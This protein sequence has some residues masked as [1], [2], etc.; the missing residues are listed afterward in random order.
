MNASSAGSSSE[1][2]L[3]GVKCAE[4]VCLPNGTKQAPAISPGIPWGACRV[5][6]VWSWRGYMGMDTEEV[7]KQRRLKQ[8]D[9]FCQTHRVRC[10][11]SSSESWDAVSLLERLDHQLLDNIQDWL[12]NHTE[13]MVAVCEVI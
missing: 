6:S 4:G 2:S 13:C 8:R 1:P 11:Q 9:L 5:R 10:G 12:A 7:T 3:A